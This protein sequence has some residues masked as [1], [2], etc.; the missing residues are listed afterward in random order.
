MIT[1]FPT[2]EKLPEDDRNVLVYVPGLAEPVWPANYD[3]GV[4]RW[5]CGMPIPKQVTHW[6]EMPEGPK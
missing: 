5:D 6:A 1:W 3:E 2:T 4:W